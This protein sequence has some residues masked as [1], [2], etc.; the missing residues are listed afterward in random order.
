M[1]YDKECNS[2]KVVKTYAEAM[3]D[4]S[5]PGLGTGEGWG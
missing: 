2:K 3:C 1:N 4:F 5:G